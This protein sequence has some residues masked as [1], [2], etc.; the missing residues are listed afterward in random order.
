M[1]KYNGFGDYRG[2]GHFSGR[3][4]LPLV[5]AGVISKKIL[6]PMDIT[7][8]EAMTSPLPSIE[9]DADLQL[10]KAMIVNKKI[11]NIP[12]RMDLDIVG[13]LTINDLL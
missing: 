4:T 2:G 13:L 1:I 8:K 9:H 11:T 6:T 12:V 7:A 5:T 10:A 3:L